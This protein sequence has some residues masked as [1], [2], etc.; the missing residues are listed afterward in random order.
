[1]PGIGGDLGC[2]HGSI[3]STP[4]SNDPSYV[5]GDI[6][7]GCGIW[8]VCCSVGYSE[9]CKGGAFDQNPLAD[10]ASEHGSE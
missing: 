2:S 10:G 1:M 3:D 7:V 6:C 8:I 4:C 5:I 9:E